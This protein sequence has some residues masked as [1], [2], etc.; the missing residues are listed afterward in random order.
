M[1]VSTAI[2]YLHRILV[3]TF[4][5]TAAASMA[6]A[7]TISLALGPKACLA[8]PGTQED[9]SDLQDGDTCRVVEFGA[10]RGATPPV[11]Y[12][13]Q[14]YLAQGQTPESEQDDGKVIEGGPLNDGAG[15]VL[16]TPVPGDS[17]L[18][19]L[20]AWSGEDAVITAPRLVRT[21]Q[22]RIIVLGMSADTSSASND[23]VLFRYVGGKWTIVTDDWSGKIK[24]PKGVEQR[25]G[26]AM[27]WPTLR[28]FGALWKQDDAECCP[29]G[30]SYIA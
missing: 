17:A 15:V 22:G 3:V 16:L 18:I 23:D 21:K 12:Q 5:A 13:L 7:E 25:H 26:N 28:A 2:I 8:A 10:I 1:T 24:I 19:P 30:G 29:T 14:A 11:Y 4:I 27:D 6:R 9:W 20:A